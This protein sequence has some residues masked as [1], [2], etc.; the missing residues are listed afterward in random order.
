MITM[1]TVLVSGTLFHASESRTLNNGEPCVTAIIKGKESKYG[2]RTR[3]WHIVAF[4]ETVQSALM[5]LSRGDSVIVQGTLK[6]EIH[7]KN[8]E[9]A[10]SF[11]V[12]A[13]RIL[14]IPPR[15]ADKITTALVEEHN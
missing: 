15:F 11:G 4:T 14:D 3:F 2:N 10:L 1:A 9:L 5:Q 7:E 8:G 12:V 13:E 6:A